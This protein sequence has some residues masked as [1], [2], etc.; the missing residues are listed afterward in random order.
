MLEPSHFW[1]VTPHKLGFHVPP[2]IYAGAQ[3]IFRDYVRM[4]LVA[5][6]GCRKDCKR[7]EKSHDSK[8][9]VLRWLI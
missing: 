1:V 4:T 8:A 3:M 7:Q 2:L 9:A 5:V 6:Q